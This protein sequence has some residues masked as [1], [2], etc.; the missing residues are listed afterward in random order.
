[1]SAGK[2][3]NTAGKTLSGISEVTGATK[4]ANAWRLKT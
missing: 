4:I 3:L 2:I 1:M